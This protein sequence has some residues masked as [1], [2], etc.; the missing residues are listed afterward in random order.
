[1][2]KQSVFVS[3]NIKNYMISRPN[4]RRPVAI[5]YIQ[6]FGPS[7]FRRFRFPSSERPKSSRLPLHEF[8]DFVQ[9][10]QRH[11][12]RFWSCLPWSWQNN[13]RFGKHVNNFVTILV[14]NCPRMTSDEIMK[15]AP[16]V[17]KAPPQ[18]LPAEC[19]SG[20]SYYPDFS[21]RSRPMTPHRPDVNSRFWRSDFGASVTTAPFSG[22]AIESNS[23]TRR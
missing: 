23:S 19:F 3:S 18:V 14:K 5:P 21:R 6:K 7:G 16:V 4:I 8:V 15:D 10:D 11:T 1:M 22:P 13:S 9:S 20:S 12:K 17:G 2:N